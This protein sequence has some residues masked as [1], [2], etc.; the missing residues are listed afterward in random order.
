MGTLVVPGSLTSSPLVAVTPPKG[1]SSGEDC[2]SSSSSSYSGAS[3]SSSSSSNSSYSGPFLHG[4]SSSVGARVVGVG[5]VVGSLAWE[6]L[7][8]AL[9]KVPGARAYLLHPW[10]DS[11]AG[12]Q[13][14]ALGII[15]FS[16]NFDSE[17]GVGVAAL[18]TVI[19]IWYLG[20]H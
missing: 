12:S 10:V 7:V 13:V 3:S 17:Q 1:F 14:V 19:S 16:Q 4:S 11:V 2:S 15:S 9:W 6:E 8:G 5:W 20:Y 18:G